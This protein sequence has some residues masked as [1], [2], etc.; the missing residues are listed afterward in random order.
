MA[1]LLWLYDV[2]HAKVE[3][4]V[5]LRRPLARTAPKKDGYEY[6]KTHQQQRKTLNPLDPKPVLQIQGAQ[7]AVERALRDMDSQQLRNARGLL[8]F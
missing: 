1:L 5:R 8:G 2:D 3:I 6:G 4:F 7:W